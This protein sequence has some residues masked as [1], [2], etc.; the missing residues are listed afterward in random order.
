[1]NDAP[2]S[3]CPANGRARRLALL[4][5]LQDAE[6]DHDAARRD[7]AAGS[8]RDLLD[9]DKA[10]WSDVGAGVAAL[11]R[12]ISETCAASAF[13]ETRPCAELVTARLS[14]AVDDQ[15]DPAAWRIVDAA[16]RLAAAER[17]R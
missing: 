14:E 6:D 5:R 10:R 13:S 7:L 9:A 3:P 8:S 11:A 12:L 17:A 4:G 15:F 1:M 2:R 16:A